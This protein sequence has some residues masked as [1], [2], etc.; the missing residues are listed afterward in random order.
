[1]EWF[2]ALRIYRKAWRED[3]AQASARAARLAAITD[4]AECNSA[5]QL[6]FRGRTGGVVPMECPHDRAEIGAIEVRLGLKRL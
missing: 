1:M 3:R 4:C 6:V 5:G 2:N